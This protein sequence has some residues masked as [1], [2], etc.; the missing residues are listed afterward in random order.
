MQ[1]TNYIYNYSSIRAV[2]SENTVVDSENHYAS[3]NVHNEQAMQ[4]SVH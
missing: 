2:V 3:A 4:R 1:Y